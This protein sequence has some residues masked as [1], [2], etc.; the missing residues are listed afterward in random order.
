M[1]EVPAGPGRAGP[2]PGREVISDPVPLEKKGPP[3]SHPL[4]GCQ[5]L[6]QAWEQAGHISQQSWLEAPG[7]RPRI[8]GF[9]TASAG[10]WHFGVTIVSCPVSTLIWLSPALP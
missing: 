9:S 4:D 3:C 8:H 10:L 1:Q 2:R 6:T 5:G 7:K